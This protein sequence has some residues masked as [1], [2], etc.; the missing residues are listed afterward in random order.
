MCHLHQNL[1]ECFLL[2]CLGW[3]WPGT[4]IWWMVEERVCIHGWE[5]PSDRHICCSLCVS[6]KIK[7]PTPNRFPFFFHTFAH[8]QYFKYHNYTGLWVATLVSTTFHHW[9]CTACSECQ[10]HSLLSSAPMWSLEICR[11]FLF[12]FFHDLVS[13]FLI[14]Y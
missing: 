9:L 8:A 10:C 11:R 13:I 2:F 4:R 1:K 14:I 7:T 3:L 12:I 5:P 6:K